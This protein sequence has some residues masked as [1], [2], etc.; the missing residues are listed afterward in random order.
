MSLSL[1]EPRTQK[2]VAI[3]V[4][5]CA[6]LYA[7]LFT[8][9][10]PFTYKAGAAE[11]SELSGS[12]AKLSS[13]VTKARQAVGSLPYLEKEFELLHEKWIRAQSL[14]P[15]EQETAS[16]LRAVTLLGDQSGIEFLLFR[17]MARTPSQHYTEHPVEVRVEGGYH[18]VATFLGRLAN[19][20]RI[21]TVRGLTVEAPKGSESDK[22]TVAS[23]TATTYTLGGTG[24]P[25]PADPEVGKEGRSAKGG[26]AKQA[27]RAKQTAARKVE[28]IK[29]RGGTGDE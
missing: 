25:P 27:N 11:L 14:L 8:D 13:D 16:L 1:R 2:I 29:S 9:L 23:F 28:E 19:M 20:E 7:Y 15:D 6:V 5:G 4:V 21:L 24:V 18:E 3:T 12:Y 10:V 17:P 26:I 22:P